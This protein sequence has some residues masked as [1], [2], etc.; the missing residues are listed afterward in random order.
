MSAVTEDTAGLSGG[1]LDR[2]IAN[3][4]HMD[5]V[6]NL[7]IDGWDD[8][9]PVA[10]G[11]LTRI[12]LIPGQRD[13]DRPMVALVAVTDADEQIVTHVPWHW[14][15]HVVASLATAPLAEFDRTEY[16]V[17]RPVNFG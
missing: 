1:A 2:H 8:V 13:R 7:A 3:A 9:A 14:L 4:R 12:G 10:D 5:V 15:I 6:A 16:R 17:P 11:V